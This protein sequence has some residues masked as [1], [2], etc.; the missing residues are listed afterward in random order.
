VQNR[1]TAYSY[2]SKGTKTKSKVGRGEGVPFI[3]RETEH[4]ERRRKT[5][6]G[7]AATTPEKARST[8]Q[9]HGELVPLNIIVHQIKHKQKKSEYVTC[10]LS[11]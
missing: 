6:T 9:L 4:Q 1:S 11:Q 2:R 5:K 8:Q 10:L 3:P 7:Q